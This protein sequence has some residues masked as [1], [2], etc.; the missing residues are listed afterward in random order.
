MD[1]EE[2]EQIFR[3]IAGP[4]ITEKVQ[5]MTAKALEKIEANNKRQNATHQFIRP[6]KNNYRPGD[7]G[8]KDINDDGPNKLTLEECGLLGGRWIRYLWLAKGDPIR[9]FDLAQ[10]SEER[11]IVQAVEKAMTTDVFTAGGALIPAEFTAG[12]ID[13]LY[14]TSVIRQAGVDTWPM[15]TGSL[16]APFVDT[17]TSSNY[18]GAEGTNITT[19]AMTTGQLQFSDKKLAALVP[20]SNDLLRNG[21]PQVDRIVRD[22]VVRNLRLKEDITMIRSDGTDGEPKGLLYWATDASNTFAANATFNAS[23][24]AA[25]FARAFRTLENNDV[26][27]EGTV[28]AMAPRTKWGLWSLLDGNS[29]Y[30]YRDEINN[31]MLL[32]RPLFST[33]QIP[34]NLSGTNSEIYLFNAP[35]C[36]IAENENLLL[37]MFDNG[38]Y[39]DG[40]AVQSGVSRDESVIRAIAK[41]DFGCQ[42][43][44]KEVVVMTT[45][46]WS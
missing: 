25:D 19:S 43:R 45:V 23:N 35:M 36:V 26:P 12:I 2:L 9:A 15:N 1:R 10:V 30:I 31:G 14:A 37:E 24:V 17:G 13:Q 38:A 28:F 8:Q 22:N 39:H 33:S 11:A 41:H 6:V 46:T 29:N 44:G 21:G 5:E 16:T 34:T 40:S 32:G 18:V 20:L 7:Y 3:D 4:V 42:H 27:I